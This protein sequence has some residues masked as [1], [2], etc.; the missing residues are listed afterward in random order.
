MTATSHSNS[1]FVVMAT[2]LAMLCTPLATAQS[3]DAA[4]TARVDH[5]L[6]KVPLID[7]HNDLPWEIR[8]RF[9]NVAGVDL[10]V[11]TA[12]LPQAALAKEA[13]TAL[14]TDIPRL[15]AGHVG[16]HMRRVGSP[17]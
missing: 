5:V 15:R 11:S 4:L 10:S 13:E 8:Q 1:A 9:G 17:R 6:A 2:V 3:S 16:T 14:M 7:G 12:S